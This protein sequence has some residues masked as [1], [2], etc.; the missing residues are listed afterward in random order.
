MKYSGQPVYAKT[1]GQKKSWYSSVADAYDRV[2]P[3]YPREIID[4]A[5]ESAGLSSGDLI[6][7]VGCGPGTATVAF[8]ELGFS[9]VCLEPSQ[10]SSRLAHRNCARYPKVEILNTT[11]EEW[12]M[13][14]AKFDAVLAASAF[15]WV[16]SEI[17][18]PKTAATLK[19]GGSLILLWNTPPQPEDE[20]LQTLDE[21][22][23]S[24]APSL[25]QPED[26]EAQQENLRNLGQAVTDSGRFK[27]PMFEIK[28]YEAS[29]SIDDY[30]ALLSTLSPYIA[31][32]RERR[33]LLFEGLRETLQKNYA[34][35]DIQTSYLSALHVAQKE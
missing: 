28:R 31:L 10:E 18:Y 19:A 23:R 6:L 7:E 16:S 11:F 9:M 25:A 2:R 12:K 3:S 29:Y 8:A 14:A 24:R 21:V 4:R 17:A 27:S 15:H 22:Y 33:D 32:D 1:L 5:V 13:E 30:M 35:K 34:G 20:V 26:L